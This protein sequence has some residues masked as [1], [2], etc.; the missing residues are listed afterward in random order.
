MTTGADRIR[1]ADAVAD[2]FGDRQ[3]AKGAFDQIGAGQSGDELETAK[4][5]RARRIGHAA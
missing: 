5:L 3:M 4:T 2:L 1:W